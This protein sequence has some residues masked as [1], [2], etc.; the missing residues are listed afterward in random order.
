MKLNDFINIIGIEQSIGIVAFTKGN[1]PLALEHFN[2][3]KQLL[4]DQDSSE[5]VLDLS[6]SALVYLK[7]KKELS[8]DRTVEY[9]VE[10]IENEDINERDLIPLNWNMHQIFIILKNEEEADNYLE[11]A[12]LELKHQSKRIKNKK[13]RTS[14]LNNIKLHKDIVDK[15]RTLQINSSG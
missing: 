15:W 11:S 4:I 7:M 8:G 14:F 6:W 10:L 2:K 13:N 3:I 9:L 12:Y 1:Y 5:S